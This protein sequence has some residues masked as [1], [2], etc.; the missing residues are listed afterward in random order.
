MFPGPAATSITFNAPGYTVQGGWINGSSTFPIVTNFSATISSVLNGGTLVKSGSGTLTVAG[1]NFFSRLQ[2]NAGEYSVV[3][4]SSLFFSDVTLA[5]AP[6]VVVTLAQN[7]DRTN[8]ASLSGGGSSGGVVRP[9]DRARTVTVTLWDSGTFR[10]SLQ[11][12]GS[13]KLAVSIFASNDVITLAGTNT[14]SGTTDISPG[15]LAFAENGSA[16]NSE[17]QVGTSGR[18][19]LDNSSQAVSNRISDSFDITVKGGGVELIGNASTAVEEFLGNL[20]Y[21]GA[22]SVSATQTGPAAALLT[23]AG[24]TRHDHAT[25][26]FMGANSIKWTGIANGSTGIVS[27]YA[28]VGN[29]WATVGGDGRVSAFSDYSL[30]I[31]S[32]GPNEHVKITPSGTTSLAA[33]KTI[34][35]VNLQN[36]TGAEVL[37]LG[38]GADLNLAAGGIASSGSAANRI[39]GATIRSQTDELVVTNQNAL[40][41][42]SSIGETVAGTALVKTGTGVLTLE[43]NNS[44]S[45]NTTINQG[46]VVVSSDANL[47]I[48]SA[49]QF[50]GGTLRAGQSFVSSKGFAANGTTLV[51]S[52]DTNGHNVA[53]S[54]VNQGTIAKTGSGTLTLT[55]SSAG[56][57][58]VSMGTLVLSNPTSG[59]ANLTGGTLVATGSLSRLSVSP[60][61]SVPTLDIGANQIGS[62]NVG[63]FDLGSQSQMT[64]RCDVASSA[65]DLLSVTGP[66]FLTSISSGTVFLFDFQNLGGA[67]PGVD[68]VVIDFFSSSFLNPGAFGFAPSALSAGWSGSFS[69]VSGQVIVNF[70][71]VPEP[72][73]VGLAV[74]GAIVCMAARR[75]ARHG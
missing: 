64:L 16:L 17:F 66:F 33:A 18:L 59:Q 35:T 7:A 73:A 21:S 63:A 6:G 62:L 15:V 28:M 53:F 25:I 38:A 52:I 54:G 3:D 69:V 24:A 42:S 26:G 57:V 27:S 74:F 19:R 49:V 31:N 13:G 23:F 43:G 68:Y 60:A 4:N 29:D 2:V 55:N 61:S 20:E 9:D 45:G 67:A 11:D 70:S 75:R 37:D 44:Y 32:A 51:G 47:G 65:C 14:Y 30:N 34:A 5:N 22:V 41:I 71:S 40:S 36:G 39:Q 46:V 56:G 1:T 8:I 72:G 10:G 12:N 48:G 50:S 58:Y